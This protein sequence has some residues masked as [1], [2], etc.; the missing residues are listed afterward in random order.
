ML[1]HKP[2]AL[3]PHHQHK[4]NVNL[5]PAKRIHKMLLVVSKIYVVCEDHCIQLKKS[6]RIPSIFNDES[7]ESFICLR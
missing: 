1:C 2:E 7:T 3:N 6:K 5:T 4:G